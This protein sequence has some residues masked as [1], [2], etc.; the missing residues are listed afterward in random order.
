MTSLAVEPS[1]RT[2]ELPPL[3]SVVIPVYNGERFAAEA[4]DSVLRQTF[5]DFE[6]IVVRDGSTD[7]TA[8]ILAGGGASIRVHRQAKG[9]VASARNA[10]VARA[11]GAFIA[12]LDAD[13]VW[14]A[15][16][17]M[18]QMPL[19]ERA[20]VALVYSGVRVVDSELR[21]LREVAPPPPERALINT[22]CVDPVH[23]PLTMT[24]VVRRVAFEEIGG[25]DERVS[26]SA[27]ADFI[28][29]ISLHHRLDCI[30]EPLALYRQHGTQMHLNVDA[31]ERDM[32]L[33][34][35]KF[36]EDPAA[37]EY[38][39]LRG[40]AAASLYYT[41]ALGYAHRRRIAEALRCAATAFRW[42]TRRV[43][44]LIGSSAL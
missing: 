17:L 37:A 28:C 7:G 14:L 19:F 29:R 23:L 31:M 8:A 2:T 20:G 10:G 1:R 39:K 13:D 24:G 26:T 33:L 42:S 35:A 18:R 36:F 5:R 32:T 16:K 34:H 30:A 40:R 9:G 43:L 12:F 41:L 6:I 25:F 3:V 15:D 27:D 22:L 11:R 21:P 44:S 4:V 38:A